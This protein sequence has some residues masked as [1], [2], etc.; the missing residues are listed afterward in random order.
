MITRG[1]SLET[2]HRVI[3][4]VQNL[5][6]Y[7]F[8]IKSANQCVL[9]DMTSVL[10]P[11]EFV[12]RSGL[13]LLSILSAHPKLRTSGPV[14]D[15]CGAPGAFAAVLERLGV[16]YDTISGPSIPYDERVPVHKRS[17]VDI[18]G[19]DILGE[20]KKAH[21]SLVLADGADKNSWR[22]CRILRAEIVVLD[23]VMVPTANCVLKLNNFFTEME[24]VRPFLKKFESVEVTKPDFSLVGNTEVYLVCYGYGKVHKEIKGES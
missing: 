7:L 18:L 1:D 17:V 21:Y 14:L 22:D 8:S 3:T 9:Y 16:I 24:V 15:L 5:Q 10:P 11:H 12:N 6:E 4:F 23:Y 20:F 2:S 13:K 19:D